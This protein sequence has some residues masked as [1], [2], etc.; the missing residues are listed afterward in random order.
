M[1]RITDRLSIIKQYFRTT[2]LLYITKCG[3]AWHTVDERMRLCP[4]KLW[5]N[6]T[7]SQM[8]TV[9]DT[10]IYFSLHFHMVPGWLKW[11]LST[12]P[13]S[14]YGLLWRYPLLSS[15]N[16]AGHD[17][18]DDVYLRFSTTRKKITLTVVSGYCDTPYVHLFLIDL[19]LHVLSMN[20]F[21]DWDVYTFNTTDCLG[22][23]FY[24]GGC[25]VIHF[26]R[27]FNREDL[28][29]VF[30]I[31]ISMS[32]LASLLGAPT[33]T[34]YS[35][36]R[37]FGSWFWIAPWLSN[38]SC[39]RQTQT[40]LS[41]QFPCVCDRFGWPRCGT[42]YSISIILEVYPGYGWFAWSSARFGCHWR[43]I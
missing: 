11:L 16:N 30:S 5:R 7:Q 33:A 10:S 15:E 27:L 14:F 19:A 18:L 20:R 42:K 3:F 29:P 25:Q 41:I 17:R 2:R 13:S 35:T 22:P 9:L 8:W 31:A 40:H 12:R 4:S 6:M 24:R 39:C 43:Y 1:W 32:T 38:I 28:F 21:D 37:K 26:P 34:P 23:E 36:F